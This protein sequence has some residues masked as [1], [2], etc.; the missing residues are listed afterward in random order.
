[1]RELM[2]QQA[3]DQ[4]AAFTAAVAAAS[5]AAAIAAIATAAAATPVAVL[6]VAPAEVPSGNMAAERPIHKLVEQF[7]KLNSPRFTSAGDSETTS[8]WIQDMDK[9]FALLKCNEE[10]K[11]VLVVYQLQGNA[12]IW[13]RVAKESVFPKGVVPVWDAFLK[14]FNDQYF[15]GSAREQKMEEF[16]R[17]RQGNMTVDQYGIKFAEL[18]QYAPRLIKNLEDKARRFKN[19]LQQELKQLLVPFNLKDYQE[20]YNQAQLLERCLNEQA[21]SFGSRFNSKRD[22]I[23]HGKKPMT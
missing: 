8:L 22:V 3:Q 2:G 19:G 6:A 18:S 20:I 10:E 1:M 13:W 5:Q 14:A 15:L 7:F 16:Q 17:L 9:S 11:V 4:A 12:N 23:H 21:A